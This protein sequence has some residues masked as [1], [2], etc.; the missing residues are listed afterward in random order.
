MEQKNTKWFFDYLSPDEAH[1]H[2]IKRIIFSKKTP[3]QN[4]D[5]V[6][7]GS[8]GKSL[9]LDGKVQSTEKDEFL[10]HETLVHPAMILHPCPEKV[11]IVGGGEGATLREILKHKTVKR[12]LMVDIDRDVVESCKEYLPEIHCGSFYDSRAGI[13]YADARK[14]LEETEEKFDVI[15]MDST[16]PIEEGPSYLLF[17]VEFFKILKERLTEDGIVAIQSGSTK[18]GELL[19]FTAIHRTLKVVFPV[20]APYWVPISSFGQPW[21]FNMATRGLDPLSIKKEE[22]DRRVG[23]RI[24]GELKFYDGTAHIGMFSLPRYL[25]TELEEQQRIIQDNKPL[26]IY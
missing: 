16:D 10:Y 22:I 15:L 2:S 26:F 5:I 18:V 14:Y 21:G 23:T 7:L 20:V 9:I 24:S 25:R 8:Y 11:F 3:Y 1:L 6:E 19:S 13:I 12:V 4:L 17:T